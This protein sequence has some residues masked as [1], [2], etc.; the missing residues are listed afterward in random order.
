MVRSKGNRSSDLWRRARPTIAI[1]VFMSSSNM[2]YIHPWGKIRPLNAGL[3]FL[4]NPSKTNHPATK[5]QRSLDVCRYSS[6]QQ[7]NHVF[8]HL[9]NKHLLDACCLQRLKNKQVQPVNSCGAQAQV[10]KELLK[11][12]NEKSPFRP[13]KSCE[14][15]DICPY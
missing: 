4:Q 11:W 1:Y 15:N 6:Q 12:T 3:I 5:L 9:F 7:L 8:V 13:E 10:G 2:R 14:C